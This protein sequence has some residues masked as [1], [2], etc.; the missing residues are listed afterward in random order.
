V[1]IVHLCERV[2][3]RR[4][5]RHRTLDMEGRGARKND[6]HQEHDERSN[7]DENLTTHEGTLLLPGKRW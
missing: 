6:E 1:K 5:H 4:G 2:L 3:G 7:T